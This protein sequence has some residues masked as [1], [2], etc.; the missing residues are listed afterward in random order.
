MTNRTD[1]PR[2][3]AYPLEL[4][5][6]EGPLLL[7]ATDAAGR[8]VSCVYKRGSGPRGATVYED[9]SL[10]R[11]RFLLEDDA[12]DRH[13]FLADLGSGR[14]PLKDL[15]EPD[16]AWPAPSARPSDAPGRVIRG[17]DGRRLGAL[18]DPAT[19]WEV[20]W[21]GT[22]EVVGASGENLGRILR[23]D[24]LRPARRVELRGATVLR[25]R[26]EGPPRNGYRLEKTADFPAAE[27]ELLL[28]AVVAVVLGDWWRR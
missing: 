19:A 27:G 21:H 10:R 15:S 4:V 14:R 17:P 20:I 26:K 9:E 28:A 24:P 2:A 5:L 16:L 6:D 23:D 1:V 12:R 25:L 8:W 7:R 18:A 11:V 22:H 3:P 13:R